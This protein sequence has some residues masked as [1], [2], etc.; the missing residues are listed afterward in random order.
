MLV[1]VP[2]AITHVEQRAVLEAT[3]KVIPNKLVRYIVNT[4]HHFDH[5]GGV[6]A[7]PLRG[8]MLYSAVI[9]PRPLPIRCGGTFSSRLA[10][11]RIRVFPVSM[12]AEPS[13]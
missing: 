11:Q 12:R 3:A 10:A 4:H 6:R 5:A 1:C 8:S 7:A 13:A 2:S 9:Q